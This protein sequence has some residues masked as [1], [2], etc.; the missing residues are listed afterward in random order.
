MSSNAQRNNLQFDRAN[1]STGQASTEQ[2]SPAVTCTVCKGSI[3]TA[4]WQANGKPVCNVCRQRVQ[5]EATPSKGMVP[6]LRASIFGLGAAIAGAAIY[7]AVLAYANLE[8]AIVAILI[9]FMVGYSVRKGAGGRGGRRLQIIALLLT[10][11]AVGLAYSPFAIKGMLDGPSAK[12]TSSTPADSVDGASKA[13]TDVASTTKAGS[14][15]STASSN[16]S[17]T[18]TAASTEA[19]PVG[20]KAIA[21]LI[22]F[23][24][25]FIF[26]LPVTVIAGTMPSGLISALIIFFGMQQ[27]WR[28]TAAPKL[29]ITGPHKVGAGQGDARAAS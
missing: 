23:M 15:P 14:V 9:G 2:T 21:V 7:Y 12:V 18:K 11:W 26:T 16:V 25:I 8:I 3:S 1:P 29:Q 4:Y 22:G 10:Y 24:V 27:A 13:P 28:M 5:A 19:K 17:P 6:L 20:A